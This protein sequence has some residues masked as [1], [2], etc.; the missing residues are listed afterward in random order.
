[1]KIRALTDGW[2]KRVAIA[3]ILASSLCAGRGASWNTNDSAWP[4]ADLFVDGKLPRIEIALAP[5]EARKLQA[6]TREFVHAT[7]TEAGVRYTG[8][9][10]HLKVQLAAFDPWTTSLPSRLILPGFIQ[11]SVFISCGES[12]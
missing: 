10:V 4:G 11:A 6:E 8:V 2:F 1:M 9:A 5:E 3:A 7:L 12:I